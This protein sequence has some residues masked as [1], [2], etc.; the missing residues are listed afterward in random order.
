MVLYPEVQEKAQQEMDAV[1]GDRLPSIDDRDSLPYL[2]CL[3]QVQTII[4]SLIIFPD[5]RL[6]DRKCTGRLPI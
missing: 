3:M 2:D 5:H 6:C 1:K 4:V